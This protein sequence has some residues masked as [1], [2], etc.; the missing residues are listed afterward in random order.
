MAEASITV[1]VLRQLQNKGHVEQR[2][3]SASEVKDLEETIDTARRPVER[4]ERS[5]QIKVLEEAKKFERAQ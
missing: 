5:W 2:V 1:V 3:L 4:F